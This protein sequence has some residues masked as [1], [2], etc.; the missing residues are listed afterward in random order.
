VYN[1]FFSYTNKFDENMRESLGETILHMLGCGGRGRRRGEA[2]EE[3]CDDIKNNLDARGCCMRER[4]VRGEEIKYADMKY[5]HVQYRQ[6]Q[7]DVLHRRE[8]ERGRRQEESKEEKSYEEES[9]EE[10]S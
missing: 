8:R 1:Y 9:L 4:R 3:A 6:R 10:K 7:E 5:C 2:L